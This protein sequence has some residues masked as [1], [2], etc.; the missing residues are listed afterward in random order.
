MPT[1][2]EEGKNN[3]LWAWDKTKS[4]NWTGR[5]LKNQASAEWRE[6]KRVKGLGDWQE[7]GIK[8]VTTAD[9]RQAAP[10]ADTRT[11]TTWTIRRRCTN[12]T[13]RHNQVDGLSGCATMPLP[14]ISP[15]PHGLG[16]VPKSKITTHQR[17]HKNVTSILLLRDVN[18]KRNARQRQQSQRPKEQKPTA[19]ATATSSFARR[20]AKGHAK[21]K[22]KGNDSKA[23]R[24]G[25]EHGQT[26]NRTGQTQKYCG[27][28]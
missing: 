2:T 5:K 25:A 6:V 13:R 26:D 12:L 20:D 1:K 28:N 3:K 7:Q 18:S 4:A 21:G 23:K 11:R 15:A 17:R 10:D 19:T 22:A 9:A 16:C 27:K 8:R 24:G 14:P